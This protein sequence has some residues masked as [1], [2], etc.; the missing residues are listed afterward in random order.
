M[1]L[2]S[3]QVNRLKEYC[4]DVKDAF[5][6]SIAMHCP[7][8]LTDLGGEQI[9]SIGHFVVKSNGDIETLMNGRTYDG[10]SVKNASLLDSLRVF[11]TIEEANARAMLI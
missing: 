10:L 6:D 3:S 2:S 4:D 9:E 1:E 8:D 7:D 11:Y 5:S